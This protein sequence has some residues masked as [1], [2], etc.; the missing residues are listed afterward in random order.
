MR[1]LLSDFSIL[2]CRCGTSPPPT[3]IQR[4]ETNAAATKETK[5]F[6]QRCDEYVGGARVEATS[7]QLR[8]QRYTDRTRATLEVYAPEGTMDLRP[9]PDDELPPYIRTTIVPSIKDV[10]D[11][12]NLRGKQVAPFVVLASTLR[13]EREGRRQEQL[14]AII[15]GDA[16]CGKSRILSALLWYAFQLDASDSLA[17]VSYTWR[18]ALNVSTEHNPGNSTT[19]FF[20]INSYEKDNVRTSNDT[21]LKVQSNLRPPLRMVCMDEFSFTSAPHYYACHRSANATLK[22]LGQPVS[23]DSTF[24]GLHLVH[25]GDFKQHPPPKGVPLYYDPLIAAARASLTEKTDKER[26]KQQAA[27]SSVVRGVGLWRMNEDVF[28]LEA[29]HRINGADPDGARLLR[30]ASLFA[31]PTLPT[32]AQMEEFVD[33][34]QATYTPDIMSFASCKPKCLVL[35]NTV[36]EKLDRRLA[37][38]HAKSINRRVV[39]WRSH[40]V[41][42]DKANGGRDIHSS[43]QPIV[44]TVTSNKTGDHGIPAVGYFFE[45]CEYIFNDNTHTH[46]GRARNNICVGK[47]LVLDSRE[48]ADDLAAPVRVLR[49][50]PLGVYVKPQGQYVPDFCDDPSLS[51]CI[52]VE[53]RTTG[54][55]HQVRYS[56]CSV[57]QVFVRQLTDRHR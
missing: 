2:C 42:A 35:R 8:L 18:A 1:S 17:I 6:V 15:T 46:L 56:T 14:R 26:R 16:G 23:E 51:G 41:Y 9:L 47:R 55:I 22:T 12:F 25:F 27:L 54:V 38:M 24:G 52:F 28:Y 19:S 13:A 30:Y 50:P 40:H 7:A 37:L 39:I 44:E 43:L 53:A 11:L 34:L 20:G 29:V 32:Y 45:D 4:F 48:P 49:F 21:L 36:R 10:V 5:A 3:V 33:A 31:S 57:F